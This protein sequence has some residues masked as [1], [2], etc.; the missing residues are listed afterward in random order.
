MFPTHRQKASHLLLEVW[1]CVV[2]SC[3]ETEI[4]FS[5][6][7]LISPVREFYR[8]AANRYKMKF[9]LPLIQII[10]IANYSNLKLNTSFVKQLPMSIIGFLP[11]SFFE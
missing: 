7:V 9:I 4:I 6:S 5:R 8:I 1:F 10:D 3:F 2:N 11:G